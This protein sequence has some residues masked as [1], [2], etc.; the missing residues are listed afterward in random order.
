MF[1]HI[2]PGI[3][4]VMCVQS[5]GDVSFVA[6][7]LGHRVGFLIVDLTEDM[8]PWVEIREIP[9]SFATVCAML[10]PTTLTECNFQSFTRVERGEDR[11]RRH[12]PRQT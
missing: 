1:N 4:A 8:I 6:K 10:L 12:G 9:P 7:D 11:S 3:N 2:S 5:L